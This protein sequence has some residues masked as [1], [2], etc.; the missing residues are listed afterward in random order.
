MHDGRWA[1]SSARHLR[2]F[3][4]TP[5]CLV[6]TSVSNVSS[7]TSLSTN[8]AGGPP[9]MSAGLAYSSS[10]TAISCF[11][12][13]ANPGPG[14]AIDWLDTDRQR[15]QADPFSVA[16][17]TGIHLAAC[18]AGIDAGS[19][20]DGPGHPAAPEAAIGHEPREARN[21][22]STTEVAR[23]DIFMLNKRPA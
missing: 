2:Y 8:G 10:S 21:A 3:A 7:G 20:H 11:R 6:R 12:T 5:A 17:T 15:D 18:C 16:G 14:D 22:C 19:A 9:P 4:I 13:F 23:L 1:A